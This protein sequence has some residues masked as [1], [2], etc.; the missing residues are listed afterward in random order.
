MTVCLVLA[1]LAL[2]G[3]FGCRK[4]AAWRERR[5]LT[6]PREFGSRAFGQGKDKL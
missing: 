2:L 5:D 1:V 6:I 4:Y 3:A